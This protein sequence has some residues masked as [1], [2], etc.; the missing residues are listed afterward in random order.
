MSCDDKCCACPQVINHVEVYEKIVGILSEAD[1]YCEPIGLQY[2]LQ[3]RS[4]SNNRLVYYNLA[5]PSICKWCIL[6]D[7]F[8]KRPILQSACYN[9]LL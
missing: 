4:N 6:T 8:S 9:A 7:M 5:L 2:L 1:S 3:L